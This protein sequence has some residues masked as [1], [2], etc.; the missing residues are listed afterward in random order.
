MTVMPLTPPAEPLLELEL[1]K[2]FLPKET[3]PCPWIETPLL[4]SVPLSKLA[5]CR[6]FLKMENFQPSGSFKSRGIGNLV[7][8]AVER[9]PSTTPLHFYASSGGNA[10]LGC[11]TAATTL[12][13]KS[14]V[15]VPT[16]TKQAMIN[17]IIAAGATQVIRYGNTIADADEYLRTNLL[18]KDPQGVYVP[19]FDH[20]DIWNGAESLIHE[21][22]QELHGSPD[23]IICSVGGGGLLIG[24]CQGLDRLSGAALSQTTGFTPALPQTTTPTQVIGVETVGCESFSQAITAKRLVTLPGITSIATSLGCTRIAARAL[25]YGLRDNVHS[26]LV[27][28][29]EAVEACIRFADDHKV[30]VEPACG[31]T[32]ALI[33][34]GRLSEVMEVKPT[35]KVVLVVCGGSNIS[36]GMMYKWK[37]EF[38]I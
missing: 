26:T 36:V 23:G 20:P 7:R 16:I 14:T 30:L 13:Q 11:V 31:A 25:E 9:S 24:I 6:I 12:K 38:E 8:C 19:P 3:Y 1:T 28:D 5:G 18:P 21:V 15:V 34:S 35:N 2:G 27:S 33:Y 4:E 29:K 10:G 17:K 32:L 37:E 22:H